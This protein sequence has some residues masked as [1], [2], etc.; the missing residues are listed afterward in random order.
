MIVGNLTVVNCSLR[1]HFILYTSYVVSYT[2]GSVRTNANTLS[3][4]IL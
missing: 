1:Y 3:I 2:W 4:A